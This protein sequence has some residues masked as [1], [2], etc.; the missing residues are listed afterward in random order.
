VLTG[1]TAVFED[2]GIALEKL[3]MATWA[4]AKRVIVDKETCTIIEGAG[5]F[6]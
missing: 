2:L 4:R 5:K 3:D 6:S 1:G